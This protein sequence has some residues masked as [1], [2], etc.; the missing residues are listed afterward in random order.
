MKI[1]KKHLFLTILLP[2][3]IVLVQAAGKHPAIVEHYYSQGIYPIIAAFFRMLFG[4]IPFSFGDVLLAL[5]LFLFLRFVYK[6]FKNKFKNWLPKLVQLTAALS[7]LYG[8]FY[9]FWGLNYYRISLAKNLGYNQTEYTTQQLLHTTSKVI[10]QLNYCHESI[11]QN[12]TLR[13]HNPYSSKK[14]YQMALNGYKNL[15]HDFPALYYQYP[16][17]KNSLMS[18]L[19][20]YNG[21]AGYF[22]PLTGEAQVNDRIPKTS[23]PTTTCHEMAHQLGYAA[24][25]EA[26]F[27]GFL[28]ANYNEDVYFKYASYRMAFGY[29]I[30]EVRKRDPKTASELWKK[31]HIGILKDFQ[32]SNQF[33]KAYQNPFE[34]WVKKGYN[35][36]LKAN[37][38]EKGTASYNYVVDL[39]ISY[40]EE[41]S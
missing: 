14:M 24:E 12:D 10:E 21:T 11:T 18:G 19:Q 20:S 17:V 15:A 31:I 7:L 38:Q 36:Y 41:K 30:Q 6:M 23:Y 33:W 22:N 8:C 9:L 35:V 32:N 2:I 27:I 16:S 1:N 40:F 13:V 29:L 34:P 37:K 3:Q 26:N 4:W 5:L 25:N 39:L 28:A